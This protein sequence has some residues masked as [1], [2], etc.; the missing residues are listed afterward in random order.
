MNEASKTL[1]HAVEA[2]VPYATASLHSM[3]EVK[4]VD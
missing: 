1:M 4:V 3:E 2:S